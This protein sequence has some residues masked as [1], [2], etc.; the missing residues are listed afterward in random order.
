MRPSIA[1]AFTDPSGIRS[2][3]VI[4]SPCSRDVM[5]SRKGH[6]G[7]SMHRWLDAMSAGGSGIYVRVLGKCEY[8]V[9]L[10]EI[11]GSKSTS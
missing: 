4:I 5:M 1:M 10:S 2:M 8:K 11:L 9:C 6:D 3:L 7:R